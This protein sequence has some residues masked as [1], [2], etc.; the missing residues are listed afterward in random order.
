M[1]NEKD[2]VL[3]RRGARQL[4]PEEVLTVCGANGTHTETVCSFNPITKMVD[5]DLHEC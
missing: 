1:L 3:S 5:G 2:R 4:T